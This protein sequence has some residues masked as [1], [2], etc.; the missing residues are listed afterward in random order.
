M[1]DSHFTT[2]RG[3]GVVSRSFFIDSTAKLLFH[4]AKER[5]EVDLSLSLPYL[6]SDDLIVYDADDQSNCYCYFLLVGEYYYYFL[7]VLASYGRKQE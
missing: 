5:E 4:L 6:W 3:V 2:L 7:F 1:E